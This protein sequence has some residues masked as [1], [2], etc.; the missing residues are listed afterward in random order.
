VITDSLDQWLSDATRGLSAES[1]ARVRE[2]IQQHYDSARE[3]G[4][5]SGIN[6]IEALGNPRT[7]NR[8]YR[9]VL[10]TEQE[11]LMAPTL[12]QPNRPNRQRILLTTTFL[13]A[14]V[15]WQT[16]GHIDPGHWAITI[17]IFCTLP[18]VW[19]F[20]PTTL[21]R[22]RIYVCLQGVRN[23]L[24]LALVWWYDG[25]MSALAIAPVFLLIDHFFSYRRLSI[26]RK[27]AAGQT[28][29]LLPEEPRLTHAEAVYL[30]TL[31]K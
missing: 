14:F 24:V 18:F 11:A 16:R 15:W 4:G 9:K 23:I 17:G 19:I 20:P 12:T 26:F 2:E 8:A 13:V 21:G 27:L 3:A 28:Y 29:S 30:K 31:R 6:A 7:A 22:S 1:A 25:W 5:D 10:L